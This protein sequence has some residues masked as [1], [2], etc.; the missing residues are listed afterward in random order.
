MNFAS[1]TSSPVGTTTTITALNSS[2]NSK[3]KNKRRSFSSAAA[4]MFPSSL[5]DRT[6]EIFDK[7]STINRRDNQREK[8]GEC[9][10]NE[11]KNNNSHTKPRRERRKR[12]EANTPGTNLL[13][14]NNSYSRAKSNPSKTKNIRI[15]KEEAWNLL[16]GLNNKQKTTSPREDKELQLRQE[17]QRAR[18][19][20]ETHHTLPSKGSPKRNISKTTS[21]G[22]NNS[23][24]QKHKQKQY[25]MQQQKNQTKRPRNKALDETKESISTNPCSQGKRNSRQ[26]RQQTVLPIDKYTSNTLKNNL[27]NENKIDNVEN[28][29]GKARKQRNK[30]KIFH[31]NENENTSPIFINNNNV[32]TS[33][34][35]NSNGE[36]KE[37]KSTTPTT[38]RTR[39]SGRRRRVQRAPSSTK[40]ENKTD[41]LKKITESKMQDTKEEKQQQ[42]E[43]QEQ[44]PE[45]HKEQQPEEEENK[46]TEE[47]ELNDN[48]NDFNS[49][50]D[51]KERPQSSI[52]S[53]LQE[54]KTNGDRRRRPRQQ[55]SKSSEKR[56][57]QKAVSSVSAGSK[58]EDPLESSQ[59]PRP[60]GGRPPR[61]GRTGRLSAGRFRVADK[62]L[63]SSPSEFVRPPR[64]S[65]AQQLREETRESNGGS[66]GGSN[67]SSSSASNSIISNSNNSTTSTTSTTSTS[68]LSSSLPSSLTSTSSPSASS[69]S[70]QKRRRD[71]GGRSPLAP[72]NTNI[73]RMRE[74]SSTPSFIAKEQHI[75]HVS[76]TE[77]QQQ[78]QQQEEIT[79]PSTTT[80]KK[81][82]QDIN[83]DD[84]IPKLPGR[85][86]FYSHTR[87]V[88]GLVEKRNLSPTKVIGSLLQ[89]PSSN[90]TI[91]VN[92]NKNN[93]IRQEGKHQDTSLTNKDVV[94][95]VV[96]VAGKVRPRPTVAV[97]FHQRGLPKGMLRLVEVEIPIISKPVNVSTKRFVQE[98]TEI[99][100]RRLSD[101]APG[102]SSIAPYQLRKVLQKLLIASIQTSPTSVI[103]S[104]LMK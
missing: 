37:I 85:S 91:A 30:N 17:Q 27:K 43:Q 75:E 5:N 9:A 68:S 18:R 86:P 38:K 50:R 88:M 56:R 33:E 41:F 26:S 89:S 94:E 95:D 34:N 57:Q 73:P 11:S 74:L 64:R 14:N 4:Q 20:E 6:F 102:F 23:Q 19:R 72:L 100:V 71:R 51:A 81:I 62:H 82:V 22:K 32:V 90:K 42:Q 79:S 16:T 39:S 21:T 103:E 83:L 65:R 54:G 7:S 24:N 77:Q 104:A 35:N 2:S 47:K 55:K 10:I 87:V 44:P 93:S 15:R 8:G 53:K 99:L 12:S 84:S 25:P 92:I 63:S 28:E 1:S 40:T 49:F 80:S 97:Q 52:E 31:N 29:K 60:P 58:N 69:A 61:T 98:R 48:I 66:N 59:P 78:Q 46:H 3:S 67:G 13:Q 36:F 45:E 70:S 96:F 101:E 76:S